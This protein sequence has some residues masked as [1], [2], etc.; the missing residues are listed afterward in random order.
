MR[1]FYTKQR[2][3]TKSFVMRLTALRLPHRRT[4]VVCQV[5]PATAP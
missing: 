1:L 5:S 3:E 4:L 2:K